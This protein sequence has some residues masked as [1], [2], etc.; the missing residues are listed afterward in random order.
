MIEVLKREKKCTNEE[1]M[2]KLY[3]EA[4]KDYSFWSKDLN[5]HFGYYI[6]FKTSLLK[7]DSM[8]NQMNEQLFS[9][10]EVANKEKH[11]IDLGCGIGGT[12]KYGIN[13]HKKLRI[14]G[15]TIVPFQVKYGNN[16]INNDQAKIENIDYKHTQ[17][18]DN[19]FDGA[20][21]I[22]SFCHSGCSK[23]ALEEAYRVLKPNSKFVMA[24]AFVKRDYKEM[25]IFSKK[26]HRGL[27]KCWSLE[28]LG[29]INRVK[30]DMENIGF[31]NVKVKNIWYR[32]APSVLHVPFAISGF[33]LR[34]IINNEE[35]KEES[36]HNMKGSFYALLTS[37]CMQDF[38]Y[39]IVSAEKNK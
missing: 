10:L 9:L 30:E 32:V 36:I 39:Y 8:L 31:K 28:R 13:N 1:E 34:K 21:A 16:F 18:S 12:M 2:I 7:R 22:E 17:F 15:C 19:K 29:N 24:D 3:N 20:M 11:I 14:T 37:L 27:S 23:E 38:G 26:V 25:N 35:L 5:M 33:I 4:T 6:P